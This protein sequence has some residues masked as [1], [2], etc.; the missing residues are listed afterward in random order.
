[1][2][3]V[4]A[5]SYGTASKNYNSCMR[6]YLQDEFKNKE[7]VILPTEKFKFTN[8]AIKTKMQHNSL[9]CGVFI[10]AFAYCLCHHLPLTTFG[11]NDMKFFRYHM[12][13]SLMKWKLMDLLSYP[14]FP[15]ENGLNKSI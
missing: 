5:D 6:R 3:L 15:I 13:C 14:E 10:C 12:L 9:D 4:F 7:K 8:K 1:M 11:R 2:E